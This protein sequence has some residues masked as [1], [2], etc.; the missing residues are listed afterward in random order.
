[1]EQTGK[2]MQII[3]PIIMVI[4]TLSYNSIF[5]IYIIVGQL[6]GMATA[7]LINKLIY[8]KKKN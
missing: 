2:S 5:A 1:M 8:Q 7:P 3:L 4:F 6:F